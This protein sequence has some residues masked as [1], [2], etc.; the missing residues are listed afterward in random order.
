MK[1][2]LEGNAAELKKVLQENKLRAARGV[3]KFT[4]YADT[5]VVKV[6]DTKKVAKTEVKQVKQTDTKDVKAGDA[7][8]PRKSKKA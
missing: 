2:I 8:K 3:I 5:K 7:K 4:P 6:A 1:Y